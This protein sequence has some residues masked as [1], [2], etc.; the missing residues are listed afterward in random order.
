MFP[1]FFG[2]GH[3]CCAILTCLVV[4]L[5]DGIA[6]V[7]E[8]AVASS[9]VVA[10]P[11]IRTILSWRCP[12]PGTVFTAD[13][14]GAGTTKG[15]SLPVPEPWSWRMRSG[16]VGFWQGHQYLN[17]GHAPWW[18]PHVRAAWSWRVLAPGPWSRRGL[19]A[20][21]PWSWRC[22]APGPWSRQ[23]PPAARTLVA[24]SLPA[25]EP[26][27]GH[28]RGGLRVTSGPAPGAWSW[29][30]PAPCF[31]DLHGFLRFADAQ[32]WAKP[33]FAKLLFRL[34]KLIGELFDFCKGEF[35]W[36]TRGN[37]VDF[38]DPPHRGSKIGGEISEH[39]SQENLQLNT[40]FRAQIHA[41]DVP[42]LHV[43]F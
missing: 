6:G 29:R 35:L 27:Q 22:L 43:C 28:A 14:P 30:V 38:S 17:Q 15:M 10:H 3:G 16:P 31:A 37:F 8:G 5:S 20:P 19:P 34:S 7:G 2:G 1:C 12:E 24:A 40:I 32:V 26:W 4:V 39:F 41:A 23:W 21:E 33:P 25:P 9:V 13:L 42:T 36:K 11:G 18:V